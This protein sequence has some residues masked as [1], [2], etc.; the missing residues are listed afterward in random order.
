[1]VGS[2]KRGDGLDYARKASAGLCTG[3][4]FDE[5][6]GSA[7]LASH[8]MTSTD[9]PWRDTSGNT[10]IWFMNGTA[11]AFTTS[12]GNRRPG[13][14]NGQCRVKSVNLMMAA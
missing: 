1:M 13:S 3:P 14:C 5:W 4:S 7:G 10:S 2:P 11:A 8:C 9:L 12:V 6:A